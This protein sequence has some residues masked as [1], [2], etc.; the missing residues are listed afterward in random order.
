VIA[1][2]KKSKDDRFRWVILDI[3]MPIMGGVDTA[4][5][6]S[7][8]YPDVK[9]LVLTMHM[10]DFFIHKLLDIG[11]NGFLSKTAEPNEVEQALYSIVD[12]D[13]YRNEVVDK[14]LQRLHG[15]TTPM[16]GTKAY[17]T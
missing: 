6:I 11:V 14:A 17:S 10:E 12:L 8:H 13:F 4:R 1:K 3:E 16:K 2:S 7:G 5:Y 9:M 15:R